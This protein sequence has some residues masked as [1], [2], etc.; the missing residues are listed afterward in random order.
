M[1]ALCTI[2]VIPLTQLVSRTKVLRV[3]ILS[4]FLK[5][6]N[7]AHTSICCVQWLAYSVACSEFP[8]LLSNLIEL[9][10][11]AQKT[12]WLG[13]MLCN[14]PFGMTWLG[15]S[16]RTSAVRRCLCFASFLALLFFCFS[17][18]TSAAL[19]FHLRFFCAALS[20]SIC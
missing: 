3:V 4:T 19:C 2:Y 16:S 18:F 10:E 8:P 12:Q 9:Q 15:S 13:G 5:W 20:S 11:S 1:L 17:I 14:V 6:N 7:G